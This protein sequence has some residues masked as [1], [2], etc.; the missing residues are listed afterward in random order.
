[1]EHIEKREIGRIYYLHPD[2][3][4]F[5]RSMGKTVFFHHSE[6]QGVKFEDLKVFSLVEFTLKDSHKG[7]VATDLL[8]IEDAMFGK[9]KLKKGER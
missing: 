7:S 1:M 9:R 4:G 3:Y 2:K 6:L 5:L 8:I